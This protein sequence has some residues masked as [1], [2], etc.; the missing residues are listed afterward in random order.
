MI[1]K[2]NRRHE[3][4]ELMSYKRSAPCSWQ[5]TTFR[6]DIDPETDQLHESA[7][8]M[9]CEHAVSCGPDALFA[10]ARGV[11]YHVFEWMLDCES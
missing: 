11:R 6:D 3:A 5:Q 10:M 4:A 7:G 2:T 1:S 8:L 9:R